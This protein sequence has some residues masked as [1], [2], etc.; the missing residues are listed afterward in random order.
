M[1]LQGVDHFRDIRYSADVTY[2]ELFLQNEYEMSVYNLD[3]AS[4]DN[5]RQRF[6]LFET[7]CSPTAIA[8][9]ASFFKFKYI[10]FMDTFF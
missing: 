6:Q 1:S 10:V 3:T 5:L 8:F 4:V 7:V 2:G 9:S